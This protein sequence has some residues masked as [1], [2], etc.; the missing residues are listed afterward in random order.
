MEFISKE[1][2]NFIQSKEG[3]KVLKLITG[4]MSKQNRRHLKLRLLD[5][6]KTFLDLLLWKTEIEKA[7]AMFL[8]GKKYNKNSQE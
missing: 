8:E 1:L 2:R 3:K 7:H 4:D 6:P 5:P